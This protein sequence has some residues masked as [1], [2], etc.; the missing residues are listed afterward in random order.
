MV[1]LSHCHNV[2]TRVARSAV[3]W[4]QDCGGS[5][6][7]TVRA[8]SS[9]FT[10]ASGSV[11]LHDNSSHSRSCRTFACH[12]HMVN[13]SHGHPGSSSITFASGFANL[14]ASKVT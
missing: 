10:L 7:D 12:S 4:R 2:R 13:G 5:I 8:T 6:A 9:S 14:S 3:D 1:N 11:K